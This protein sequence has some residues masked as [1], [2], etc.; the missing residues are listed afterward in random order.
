MGIMRVFL[1][2]FFL[3]HIQAS[4]LFAQLGRSTLAEDKITESSNFQTTTASQFIV[5]TDPCICTNCFGNN[6]PLP[7][8]FIQLQAKRLDAERVQL[9]WQVELF[10]TG[11]LSLQRSFEKAPDFQTVENWAEYENPNTFEDRNSFKGWTYYRLHWQDADGTETFSPVRAVAGYQP[12][13]KLA[14][15]PNPG[16]TNPSVKIEGLEK[17][18]NVRWEIWNASGQLQQSGDVN[19]SAPSFIFTLPSGAKLPAGSYRIELFI[20]KKPYLL[21]WQKVQ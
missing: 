12:P 1:V 16:T 18:T 3:V 9:D 4:L 17:A 14:L 15:F 19:A 11:K 13:L 2:L 20:D 6:T 10:G 7:I 21:T 8:E 5:Q